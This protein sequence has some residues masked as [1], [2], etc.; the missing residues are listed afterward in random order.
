MITE[1]CGIPENEAA[2]S[3][4]E[5]TQNSEDELACSLADRLSS[6][7]SQSF[8]DIHIKDFVFCKP[9]AEDDPSIPPA[10]Q[11]LAGP[12]AQY[13]QYREW[14]VDLYLDTSR[15]ECNRS[16]RCRILKDQLLDEVKTVWT[17]LDELKLRAWRMARQNS[18]SAPPCPDP[19]VI[20]TDSTQ[21]V[22]TCRYL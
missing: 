14:I 20:D 3:L 4:E 1:A 8:P 10:L 7:R 5:V 21:V 9:S 13:L 6:F 22:D 16:E 17:K 15:M 11:S 18:P 2:S 19:D 12:N